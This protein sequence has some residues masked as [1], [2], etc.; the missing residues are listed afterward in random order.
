MSIDSW[1]PSGPFRRIFAPLGEP[2]GERHGL[3]RR[4]LLLHGVGALA[5]HL[6]E[7]EEGGQLGNVDRVS[8][9][10]RDVLRGL[11]VQ[12]ALEIRAQRDAARRARHDGP[13]RAREAHHHRL[14]PRF[15]PRTT[16]L[17]Q[18]VEEGR[19]SRE[20]VR[21]G[22][23]DLAQDEHALRAI[24]LHR[25]RDLGVDQVILPEEVAEDGFHRARREPAGL[26]VADQGELK[27]PV[28]AD[29]DLAGEILVAPDRDPQDVLGP[30]TVLLGRGASGLTGCG[31]RKAGQH[32]RRENDENA[33][34]TQSTPHIAHR[35][36]SDVLR[37]PARLSRRR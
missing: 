23:F 34:H 37:G 19:L 25:D 20:G 2:A 33:D 18:D 16:R 5:L 31:R 30:D 15:L 26:D 8:V 29:D 4:G 24:F 27:R 12:Q 32:D 13:I 10:E 9:L 35:T 11:T 17:G 21:P 36:V 3:E 1:A 6:A 22:L 7:D 14:A 28:G